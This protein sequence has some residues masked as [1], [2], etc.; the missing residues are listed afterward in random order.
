M[1]KYI[2]EEHYVG[3]TVRHEFTKAT[4]AANAYCEAVESYKKRPEF[5][6]IGHGYKYTI[7]KDGKFFATLQTFLEE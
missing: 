3:H 5:K 6:A 4:E 7:K 2:F 1:K